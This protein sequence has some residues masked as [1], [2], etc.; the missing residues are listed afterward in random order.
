M[1]GGREWHR[2]RAI[3]SEVRVQ[4][5]DNRQRVAASEET[6]RGGQRIHRSPEA[7]GN[8]LPAAVECAHGQS[9]LCLVHER[10]RDHRRLV[11][12]Q[13]TGLLPNERLG[14]DR[15]A[16]PEDPDAGQWRL[17]AGGGGAAA[18]GVDTVSRS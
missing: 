1:Q 9:G 15:I 5:A 8:R 16:E 7:R 6:R 13:G 2:V 4:Q 14:A 10:P 17:A 11:A 3:G 12:R 18:A